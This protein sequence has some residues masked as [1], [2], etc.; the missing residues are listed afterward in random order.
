MEGGENMATKRGAKGKPKDLQQLAKDAERWIASPEGKQILR[1]IS[2]RTMAITA[3][4]R[5]DRLVD[6]KSLHKPISF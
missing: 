3:Q 2:S 5:K 6:P 1:E 4:L